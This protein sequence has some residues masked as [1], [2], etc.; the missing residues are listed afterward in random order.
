AGEINAGDYDLALFGAHGQG[1]CSRSLI[2]SVVERV[3]RRIQTDALIVRNGGELRGGRVVVGVDGSEHS[4]RALRKAVVLARTLR[5][6]LEAV[7]VFNPQF[8]HAIFA[9]MAGVLTNEARE[10]FNLER[11]KALHE[12]I[13]DRGLG[14]VGKKH[15]QAAVE[16]AGGAGV[17]IETRLLSGK[18]FAAI[19]DHVERTEPA[20]LV[21]GRFGR[22]RTRCSD[23]GSTAENL[24]R[25]APCH[26]LVVGTDVPEAL[27]P[28]MAGD[29]AAIPS[30]PWTEEAE[31]MLARAPEF[32]RKMARA[33]IQEWARR[34]REPVVNRDIV[35]RAM[36]DLLPETMWRGM[37][38]PPE[39][40]GGSHQA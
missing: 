39:A 37:L 24:V 3:T 40:S 17:D 36:Q 5:M 34:H 1:K 28:A 18:D 2:G 8:H 11:Q 19:L 26:V 13:I 4:G 33:S 32:V 23:I 12:R 20:L 38:R 29:E 30:L 35:V 31:A 21:V 14:E 9:E 10:V 22:H 15:L 27:R 16:M 6:S 7:H 25:L